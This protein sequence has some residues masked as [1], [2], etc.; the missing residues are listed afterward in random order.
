MV[1]NLNPFTLLK[2]EMEN[3]EVAIRVNAIH[4]L[5]T[6]V[7]VVGVDTFKTQILPYIEGLVKKEDDEVLF[8]IAEELGKI[9][10]LLSGN[11]L[12][13]LAPLEVLAAVEETVVRDR[14]VASLTALS[15]IMTDNEIQNNYLPL[16]L[17]LAS[18]EW[19]TGRVS[20]VNL[21]DPIYQR[22]SALKEKLRQKFIELCNEETPMVRRA[23]ASRIG[24]LATVVSKEIVINE[25]IPIFKQLSGDE[26]DSVKVL[27]LN[28][29]KQIAMLLTKEENK[30]LTLPIIIGATEDK[31]WKIRLALAKNFAA[32]AEAFGKEITDISLIQIFTTLLKDAETDV[33]IAAVQSLVTFIKTISVDKLSILI[34]HI[35]TLAKDHSSPVRS[36]ICSVI[37][38]IIPLLGRDV[39]NSKLLPSVLELIE[40][41]D[42][43]VK[44]S[45]VK[46]LHLFAGVF[47]PE[48]IN[49]LAP[50][51]KTLLEDKRWR[52]RESIYDVLA[53]LALIY[54]NQELFS[55]HIEPLFFTFLKDRANTIREA[56]VRRIAALI[57]TFKTQWFLSNCLP[58]LTETLIKSNPYLLR[59]TGLYCLKAAAQALPSETVSEKILPL[60][61]KNGKDDVANVRIVVVRIIK[62]L[63]LK[64][65]NNSVSFQ[66]KPLLQELSNDQ[67]KDVQFYAQEALLSI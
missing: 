8:A 22:A 56:G 28:N 3:D 38:S 10:T 23:V 64:F 53:D 15:E 58:K 27:C 9:S 50:H 30:T 16:V 59:I 32:L 48:L 13:L 7:T 57:Q 6:I 63:I 31:S 60:L 66:V 36:D 44:I 65:D 33:R 61:L 25:L 34:P 40:D 1:D 11:N 4:R 67:D 52:V 5:R 21:I 43:T 41:K 46:S 24:N 26:Q 35:Q 51:L 19:F 39:S 62:S 14:A 55:R 2:E 17:R 42:A 47:G 29:L 45:C 54:Q 18:N 20:A 49:P 37:A 12:P